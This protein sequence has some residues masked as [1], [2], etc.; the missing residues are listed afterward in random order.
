M[1]V[2]NRVGL[3]SGALV[4]LSGFA[5]EELALT[6]KGFLRSFHFDLNPPKERIGS[7]PQFRLWSR[8]R[9]QDLEIALTQS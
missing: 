1:S 5:Q 8:P 2:G 9:L 6:C 7:S 3:K 4:V